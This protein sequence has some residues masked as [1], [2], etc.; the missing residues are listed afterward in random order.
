MTTTPAAVNRNGDS[1]VALEEEP[2]VRYSVDSVSWSPGVV[3]TIDIGVQEKYLCCSAHDLCR[4]CRSSGRAQSRSRQH[5]R[6][7]EAN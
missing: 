5:N 7:R 3:D 4:K 2:F 1:A 6:P